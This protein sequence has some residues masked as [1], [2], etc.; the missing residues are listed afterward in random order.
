MMIKTFNTFIT[1]SIVLAVLECLQKNNNLNSINFRDYR[2]K[3]HTQKP[4]KRQSDELLTGLVGND[5]STCHF[6]K[7]V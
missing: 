6:L 1:N 4:Q 2:M 5:H 3:S 7:E